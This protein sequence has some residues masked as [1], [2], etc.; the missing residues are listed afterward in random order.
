MV[1][2][3]SYCLLFLFLSGH[4]MVL[5]QS[6]KD[7]LLS[8][9]PRTNDSTKVVIY[10][11]LAWE[12]MT[13]S[14]IESLDYA[15]KAYELS[16]KKGFI[17][18]LAD[19]ENRMGN[20]YYLL[21]DYIT[22][23][24]YYL[25]SLEKRE[26]IHD[27]GGIAGS[28]NNIALI[29]LEY[30]NYQKAIEYLEKSLD[31]HA[32]DDLEGQAINMNNLTVIYSELQDSAMALSYARKTLALH[33]ALFNAEGIA[34][35]NN[36]MGDIYKTF[37]VLDKARYHQDRALKIYEMAHNL[38]G[39]A[40][41]KYNIAEILFMEKRYEEA[42]LHLQEALP[43]ATL[44]MGRELLSDI[45]EKLSEYYEA[46]GRHEKALAHFEIYTAYQDTLFQQ[47]SD[48]E[49]METQMIFDTENQLKEIELL[50]KDKELQAL[51]IQKQKYFGIFFIILAGIAF[52]VIILVNI[53]IQ[54]R[55]T[56]GALIRDKN[57]ELFYSNKELKRSELELMDLNQAKDKFFSIIAHDLI[58]PFNS[59]LGL[60]EI[61]VTNIKSLKPKEIRKYSSWIYTSAK[62][63]Y[64]LVENLLQ[65]SRAQT[66][67]INYKPKTI[68]LSK[69]IHSV[70]ALLHP[71][72]LEKNIRLEYEIDDAIKVF[73]DPNIILVVLR[74]LVGNAI[75]FT[76]NQGQVKMKANILEEDMVEIVVE[77]TGTGIEIEDQGKVFRLDQSLSKKGTADEEGTGLGLILC[78]EFVEIMGGEIDFESVP[79][80]GTKFKFTVPA[81]PKEFN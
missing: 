33:E 4:T 6:A 5:G 49:T 11:K 78:K 25:K 81:I 22:S 45:H 16:E 53:N 26:Q 23:M 65:W 8:Q 75:K 55:N 56:T 80:K 60:S 54:Y 70:Q 79:G 3:I 10:N 73:A 41:S 46:T 43:L 38:S 50:T 68:L 64:N 12:F 35:I 66:G 14:L 39:I 47:S 15:K 63:L 30:N 19:A 74:N 71:L 21:A 40:M 59:F 36:N 27:I 72:A 52:T 24:N 69:S 17:W 67:K 37:K 28:Y 13:T 2:I 32:E 62:N 31:L 51:Q 20:V 48:A 29:Y 34:D 7:T 1:R 58:S 76:P 61:L 18:G 57:V 42:F 9:L 44:L 77:D